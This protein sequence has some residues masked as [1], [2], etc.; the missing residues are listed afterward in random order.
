[1]QL[2]RIDHR[3]RG[4]ASGG[5]IGT[6]VR[7]WADALRRLFDGTPDTTRWALT[8]SIAVGAAISA[9]GLRWTAIVLTDACKTLPV[10]LIRLEVAFSGDQFAALLNAE[11][12]CAPM[13]KASFLP[14]YVFAVGYGILLCAIC[15]WAE[16][17]RRLDPKNGVRQPPFVPTWTQ[18]AVI[19]LPI[20]AMILDIVENACLSAFASA[21]DVHPNGIPV[22]HAASELPVLLGSIASALKWML[23]LST[24]VAL[25]T[26]IL[27]GPR[28][29]I[30]R[31][32]RFSLAAVLVGAVPLAA[33]GQGQDIL[34]RVAEGGLLRT[35]LSMAAIGF[36]A[37][38]VWYSGRRLLLVDYGERK[39]WQG[40]PWYDFFARNTPRI[41]GVAFTLLAG[42]AFARAAFAGTAFVVAT[43]V[44]VL[45]G[46]VLDKLQSMR[47]PTP[48]KRGIL[49]LVVLICC[50][51]LVPGASPFLTPRIFTAS[52][53]ALWNLRVGSSLCLVLS[54]VLYVFVYHRRSWKWTK[55]C[56]GQWYDAIPKNQYTRGRIAYTAG[57]IAAGLAFIIL[58]S[59]DAVVPVARWFGP[60]GV[61]SLTTASVVF[62]GGIA[63]G[64]YARWRI[65]VIRLLACFA[66]LFSAWNENHPVRYLDGAVP[67]RTSLADHFAEWVDA[68]LHD[69][70]AVARTAADSAR[71]VDSIPMVL[72][73]ASG[74]GL[75]AAYWS[76]IALAVLQ[77]SEPSFARHVFAISG[78]SGGSLGSA[79]F[80]ALV[81]DA[82]PAVAPARVPCTI[83]DSAATYRRC[84]QR[85]MRDDFLSPVLAKLVG[86]D[87]V[88]RFFP[89]PVEAADR[90]IALEDSWKSSYR[91]L[92][93]RATFDSGIVQ[94]GV[95]SVA[96][97]SVPA[98]FLNATHVETGRRYVASTLAQ[99]TSTLRDSRDI[100]G[101]LSHD[102]SLATAV[103]NSARFPYVSPAGHLDRHDGQELG[104][105]V[106][107]GY[108]ENSGLVT[109]KEIYD[110]VMQWNETSAAKIAPTVVYLCNDPIECSTPAGR[111][112]SADSVTTTH[113]TWANEIAGPIRA[114]LD[115][116]S[117]RGS[118]AKAQFVETLEAPTQLIEL[119][120]CGL[121]RAP[122]GSV[123]DSARV[124]NLPDVDQR[125][126]D[127]VVSPPLGWLLSQQARDWMDASLGD[128]PSEPGSCPARNRD[129]LQAVLR[130]VRR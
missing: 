34:E 1:L 83:V 20:A 102:L 124:R 2:I 21:V 50:V 79:L 37:L 19:L 80:V 130:R 109:L 6:K 126:R 12:Q 99:F 90:S 118:L 75:R 45:A 30:L 106:D 58:F 107:G 10:S 13:V 5:A 15:V 129:E 88:Q 71:A 40:D 128:R 103:H 63:V 26:E 95:D 115:T 67:P 35:S 120:V 61:L 104:R 25:I 9:I 57:G 72:V 65:P 31:A 105:V 122:P 47:L 70:L 51:A 24:A 110:A 92:T 23:L 49:F 56:D 100:V 101:Q 123:S 39:R 113:A 22:I 18:S 85:Y 74:G 33:I 62:F 66:L 86:P 112:A 125:K 29:A 60:L 59:T 68:R 52:E 28:G 114:L 93:A 54:W 41:L 96:R 17:W 121:L 64:L 117:A 111:N 48:A 127:R 44:S 108:F 42:F 38:M 3:E 73:A 77:D 89:Y 98:L 43:G 7:A 87:F 8:V 119:D 94:L 82:H 97:T 55:A 32:L 76:G 84:V 27:S 91:T 116:R 53:R 16:R 81:H 4:L 78:V 46:I 69:R 36:A 14:D 11:G